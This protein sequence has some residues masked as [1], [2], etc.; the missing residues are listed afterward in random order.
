M[1]YEK[2]TCFQHFSIKAYCTVVYELLRLSSSNNSMSLI[3]R[4]TLFVKIGCNIGNP[5]SIL[6]KNGLYKQYKIYIIIIILA[7]D[8][9]LFIHVAREHLCWPSL[10]YSNT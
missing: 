7:L 8:I 1:Y 5:F 10:S 2:V 6:T 9:T 3:L 4:F